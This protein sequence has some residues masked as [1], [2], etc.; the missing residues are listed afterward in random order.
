MFKKRK[1]YNLSD[2]KKHLIFTP[3]IF[4]FIS[5]IV[6]IIVTTFVLEFKKNNEITLVLQE[7]TFKKRRG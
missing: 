4:V 5:A 2:I 7:D 6:S 1:F 3:L